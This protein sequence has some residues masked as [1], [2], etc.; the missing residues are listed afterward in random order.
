MLKRF[1]IVAAVAAGLCLSGTQAMAQFTKDELKCESGTAK[2]LGKQVSAQSSCT[3]KCIVAQR[4]TTGP[5][6]ACFDE[7]TLPCIIDP[8]KGPAA[9]AVASIGKACVKDCPECYGNTLCTTGQPLVAT[10]TAM[11]DTQGPIVF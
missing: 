10:T 3:S 4:K 8:L 5:Y 2:A 9:K 6:T 11:V 7:N 1:G